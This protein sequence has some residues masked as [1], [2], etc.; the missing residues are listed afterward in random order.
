MVM[1]HE[2]VFE[3]GMAKMKH[4][5]T[6]CIPANESITFKP[7]A[8]HVMLMQPL[9]DL[10]KMK[11]VYIIVELDDGQKLKFDIDFQKNNKRKQ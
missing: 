5:D 6:L 3:D 1:L 7:K 10:A 2:T 9:R 8:K 11:G 4:V